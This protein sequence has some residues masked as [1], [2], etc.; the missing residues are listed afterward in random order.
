MNVFPKNA[1]FKYPW[2]AYQKKFLNHL[3]EYLVDNHL[4]VSAPA[5]SGKTVLGLEVM[6]RLGKP[7]LIVAPTLAIKNQWI[8]R[9]C[10]LFLNIETA[11]GWISSDIRKPGIITVTTYQ[12][13]H[14]AIEGA[15][16]EGEIK[17]ESSKVPAS[18]II[19]RLQQKK[20][21]TFILDEAHHLKNVWWRSLMDLKNKIEPTVVSLTATPPFDVSGSE[22]QKY[23]QLNGPI[24]VEIS[25]PELMIEGDLCPHQ[26][27]VHFTLPSQEEQTKIEYYHTQALGFFEEIKKDVVFLNAIE[28]HPLYQKPLEHLDWIYENISSYTSGLVYLHFRG[29]E[30]PQI[31]FEIIGDQQEYIPEFDFFWMEELLEFYLLVDQ[32]HFKDYEDHRTDLGNRLKRLGFFEQKTLS[33]FNSKRLNQILNS[34]IGKLQGIKDIVDFEFSVLKENLRLVILTDFIKKEY[35]NSGTQNTLN[36]DKIGAI[37]IFE[38]LRRENVQQKRIGVLTG[39]LV[40]IPGSAKSIFEKLCTK[41]ELS[42]ISLFP[43]SYDSDYFIISLTEQVKHDI[44]HIITEIFQSGEIHILIGT[45][46]L[47]GEGWDAPKMNTLILA[48]FI[49][50]FVL[51]NQMRGRVIRTDKDVPDKT[52]NIWHLVCFDPNDENGGQDLD[53]MKR[54]FRTFVGI[55]NKDVPTIENNFERLNVKAIETKEDVLE[56]NDLFFTLAKGRSNLVKRWENALSQGNILVEEIQVPSINMAG[57][58]EV[59]MDYVGKMSRN[60]LKVIASSILLFWQNLLFGI[61]R[62]L[63][64]INS[65]KTFSVFASLFGFAGFVVYG[66]KLY[67]SARQYWRYRDVGKQLGVLAEVVLY[68]L[69]HE[70]IIRTSFEKLKIVSSSNKSEG[71]FCYLKGGSQFEN[72]QFI[73]TLQ[74]LVSQIDNPRYILKQQRKFFFLKKEQY[75]PVPEVFAKNKKSAEFFHKNWNKIVGASELIFTRTI[76]GRKILLKL[77]FETLLKRNGRIEH[78]HKWTR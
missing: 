13:V 52:G 71:S 7:T 10:E 4:H 43:L 53:I 26:D 9:F 29:K 46:S 65:V 39:S 58:Q 11:P 34:S 63:Q 17:G 56:V 25:V 59:K 6:L 30:I 69:I 73:Q 19:K 35:L 72:T 12:G 44:V 14:A 8:Q 51:S 20:V 40:I 49:S 68:G 45:K 5:G 61:F 33:F 50:S 78:L 67:R 64:V 28:Q 22:W 66:R 24:D 15:S 37:P 31:H 18:E 48:S 47:L 55:S 70:K 57:M 21:G 36:L 75:F 1:I 62:N 2:R 23:I 27:L 38:K 32:T 16:E 54:R 74:E 3:D 76:D 41:K 77:R 42:R 60:M